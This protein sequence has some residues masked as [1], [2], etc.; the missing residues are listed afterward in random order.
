M[1]RK[2][3]LSAVLKFVIGVALVGLLIFL[4]AGSLAF[5]QGWLLMGVLFVPMLCAGVILLVRNPALLAKRLNA[6]ETQTEQTVVVKLSGLMFVVGFILAGLDYRFGWLPLPSWVSIVAA[7]ILL[8]SYWMYAEVLRENVYL[9]RTIEVQD[10]QRVID[11]GLYSV[12]R[13]PMYTAT[14]W[15]FL[16]MPLVLGS[17]YASLVFIFYP[18]L[19]VT[20]IRGEENLL[21]KELDGYKEYK[22]RVKY[23]LIPFVW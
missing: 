10:G 21:E 20:R 1:S 17:L 2:Q 15:L 14:I 3:T 13:H 16:S 9:S 8:L 6:K 4:S 23:R 5:W 19:I 12:V 22:Q 11:T 18:L 7:V